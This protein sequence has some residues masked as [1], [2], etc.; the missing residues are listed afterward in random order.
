VDAAYPT[1]RFF[2]AGTGAVAVNVVA[3]KSVIP[4]GIA[5]AGDE[6]SPTLPMLT[7]SAVLG[8]LS[9]GT[10]SVSLSFTG[11]SG[12]PQIDDVFIDPYRHG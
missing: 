3:G 7:S 6:W 5:V 11:I 10:A 12:D 1:I 2:I 8:A 9:G 4:A